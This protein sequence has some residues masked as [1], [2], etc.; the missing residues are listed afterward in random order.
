[1]SGREGDIDSFR[2]AVREAI[3][4]TAVP[5]LIAGGS[6]PAV[7]LERIARGAGATRWF[8]VRD[9]EDLAAVEQRLSPGSRVSFYFDGRLARDVYGPAI[10]EAVLDI[11]STDG[12]AVIARVQDVDVELDVEFIAGRVELEEYAAVLGQAE[13]VYG[14]F[15]A[16]DNDGEQAVTITIPDR[17]GVIRPHPY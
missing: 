5:Q 15:P 17:D 13:V 3:G 6:R 10:A 8:L 4:A 1:V 11:A 12:D 9:V 7:V 2:I 16:A 14:H